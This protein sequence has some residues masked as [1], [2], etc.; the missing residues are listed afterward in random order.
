MPNLYLPSQ[1]NI[2]ANA[3]Y[4]LG[5][6]LLKKGQHKEGLKCKR[7]GKGVIEIRAKLDRQLKVLS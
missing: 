2:F 3:L 1:F 5:E 6:A 7:E 4:G